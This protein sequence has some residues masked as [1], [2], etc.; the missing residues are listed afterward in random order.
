MSLDASA[1]VVDLA[2]ALPSDGRAWS[3]LDVARTNARTFRLR[4]MR[5]VAADWHVHDAADEGFLVL[6]GEVV[7]DVEGESRRLG[8]QQ[9]TIVPAGRRHRARAE[10]EALILVF[11]A[12]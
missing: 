8:P 9:M 3:S 10:G 12:L 1:G 6:A 2:R 7:I 4:R 5:D 11:D